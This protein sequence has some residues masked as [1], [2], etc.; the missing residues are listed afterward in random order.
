MKILF[1]TRRDRAIR[2]DIG[3][4]TPFHTCVDWFSVT[5]EYYDRNR[6]VEYAE[7]LFSFWRHKKYSRIGR[8]KW[9]FFH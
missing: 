1:Q 7:H 9:L 8:R 3:Y 5:R 6:K 2:I 4:D